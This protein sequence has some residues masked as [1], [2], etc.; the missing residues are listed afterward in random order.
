MT[1]HLPPDVLARLAQHDWSRLT[2]EQRRH[3]AGCA[4]CRDALVEASSLAHE[5]EARL[6]AAPAPPDVSAAILAHTSQRPRPA[7]I[8]RWTWAAAALPAAAALVLIL[9]T[10]TPGGGPSPEAVAPI[11]LALAQG[12]VDA[13]VFPGLDTARSGEAYRGGPSPTSPLQATVQE[14]VDAYRSQPDQAR[15]AQWVVGGYLALDDLPSARLFADDALQRHPRDSR[16][17]A[18][19]G[20]VAFR[21]GRLAR[22]DSLLMAALEHGG[23]NPAVRFNV[24]ILQLELGHRSQAI[25]LLRQLAEA[26]GSPIATRAQ[27]LLEQL[28]NQN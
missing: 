22:S 5:F 4:R 10:A 6:D 24:A 11:R 19:A 20:I 13:M 27:D 14:L 9:L 12:P 1:D 8:R 2:P 15:T 17:L 26:G 28:N 16:L 18:A 23:T 25:T 3:L 21:E 7:R